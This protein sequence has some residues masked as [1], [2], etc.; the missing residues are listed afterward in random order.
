MSERKSGSSALCEL[1][2]YSLTFMGGMA[3]GAIIDLSPRTLASADC[4]TS[5][6][7]GMGIVF[8]LVGW[9]CLGRISK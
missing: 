7:A 9:W 5:Q 8:A 3:M 2:A 1:V 6:G 4:L